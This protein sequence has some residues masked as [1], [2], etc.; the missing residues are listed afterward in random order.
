MAFNDETFDTLMK[1]WYRSI[2]NIINSHE[3]KKDEL[4]NEMKKPEQVM[5][6]KLDNDFT[7]IL[8]RLNDRMLIK[9]IRFKDNTYSVLKNLKTFTDNVGTDP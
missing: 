4:V 2:E 9:D 8:K 1:G 6:P 7:K 5:K 3:I